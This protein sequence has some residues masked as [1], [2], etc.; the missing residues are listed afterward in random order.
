MKKVNTPTLKSLVAHA[1]RQGLNRLMPKKVENNLDPAGLHILSQPLVHGDAQYIRAT[2]VL[3]KMKDREE[4]YEGS[5]DFDW[6]DWNRIPNHTPIEPNQ[7]PVD[8][9]QSQFVQ[10]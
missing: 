8:N 2:V 3:C 5:L 7:I 6:D 9:L 4:P 10:E 1:R